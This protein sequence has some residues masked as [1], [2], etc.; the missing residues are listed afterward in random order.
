MPV[1]VL[2]F[3]VYPESTGQNALRLA[4]AAEA[5]AET[6]PEV[7]IVICP[8]APVL[9]LVCSSLKAKALEVFAQ[10]SDPNQPGAF[11]GSVTLEELKAIG[12]SGTLLNHAEKK[13]PHH[14]VQETIDRAKK[15]GLRVLACA[16]DVEEGSALAKM[17]PWAIAV[18]PPELIG[19]GVSVSTAKPG[20]VKAAVDRIKKSSPRVAVLVGAGVSTPGDVGKCIELGA[21]GVLLA[22]AFAKAR[23]P[24]ALLKQ[25]AG[26]A[27]DA[28]RGSP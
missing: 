27:L 15:V 4:R 21:Q 2:N 22:S 19:T 28:A 6:V 20:V 14:Q 3:K 13:L 1:I 7:D 9:A 5:V 17:R 11:T 23:N 10:H 8:P 25:M 24:E 26:G 18:E 16:K 12:C